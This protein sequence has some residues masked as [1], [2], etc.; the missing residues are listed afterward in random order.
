MSEIQS[1]FKRYEKK[2]LLTPEQYLAVKLGMAPYMIPDEHPHY[3]ICNI[4]FD[5]DRY[6][7]I[8]TSLEKPV[9]K[10]KLRMRSYGVPGNHDNVFVEIKKK[11]DG[12]VYKRRITMKMK[13]AAHYLRCEHMDDGSQISREIDYFMELYHPVPKVFIAYDRE[14]YASANDSELRV[15]FDTALRAR[16]NDL[17]LRLGSYG[18]P[19]MEDDLYLMEIKI[20]GTAPLWLAKL[21]SENSIFPVSFSKYGTYYK[22]FILGGRSAH[23]EKEVLLSA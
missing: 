8:S 19:L 3:S 7:L 12:V 13:D 4:Y 1:C 15:T 5:T 22:Q 6:D 23:I 17:D 16:S 20:P 10:E 18:I 11:Y 9:Y 2:Y 14:A 21:L